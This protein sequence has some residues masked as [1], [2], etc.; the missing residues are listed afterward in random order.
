MKQISLNCIQAVYN[1]C[2]S[3]KKAFS[4]EVFHIFNFN[5][6]YKYIYIFNYNIY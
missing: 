2:H 6:I 4:F 1:K 5:T 3:N